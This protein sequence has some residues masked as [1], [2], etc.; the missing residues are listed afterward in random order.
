MT[1]H[2]LLSDLAAMN[3]TFLIDGDSLLLEILCH[4]IV[5]WN[6]SSGEYLQVAYLVEAFLNELLVREAKF[7]LVFFTLT[8]AA[9]WRTRPAGIKGSI[10]P[11]SLLLLRTAV[12]HHL[13]RH[14]AIDVAIYDDW[15][16]A[17]FNEFLDTVH[18]SFMLISPCINYSAGEISIQNG[19]PLELVMAMIS[20]KVFS[21]SVALAFL[22]D[23]H[24]K[25]RAIWAESVL[26]FD[27][28]EHNALNA[29][30][31]RDLLPILRSV[32]NAATGTSS[33]QVTL[34]AEFSEFD[35]PAVV[36]QSTMVAKKIFGGSAETINSAEAAALLSAVLKSSAFEHLEW[37]SIV[38]AVAA[39][40]YLKASASNAEAKALVQAFLVQTVLANNMAP[41][42][43]PRSNIASFD[44]QPA[45]YLA[46]LNNF[47]LYASAVALLAA[48]STETKA[49]EW[50]LVDFL[51]SRLILSILSV[52]Q[53]DGPISDVS[54]L[55]F[56]D[57]MLKELEALWTLASTG[58]PG[59]SGLGSFV[60]FSSP[61]KVVTSEAVSIAS[62]TQLTPIRSSMVDRMMAGESKPELKESDYIRWQ[63]QH[64]D[65]RELVQTYGWKSSR[66]LEYSSLLY[67]D[68][69]YEEGTLHKNKFH[70]QWALLAQSL[71]ARPTQNAV[72]Q[73]KVLMRDETS[74]A[75]QLELL[76]AKLELELKPKTPLN[77]TREKEQ[78]RIKSISNAWR[79][80]PINKRIATLA[81]FVPTTTTAT[82][83][84]LYALLDIHVEQLR[85][86]KVEREN[87]SRITASPDSIQFVQL[88]LKALQ[89][90]EIYDQCVSMIVQCI[91]GLL[92]Y[93]GTNM[94]DPTSAVMRRMIETLDSLGLS[95][96]HTPP[97]AASASS[98]DQ[99]Q[100]PESD[101]TTSSAV[102]FQLSRMGPWMKRDVGAIKDERAPRYLIDSWQKNVL[103]C[104]DEYKSSLVV[105]PT[106]AGKSFMA[107]HAVSRVLETTDGVLVY[108]APTKALVSQVVAEVY[109]KFSKV[110]TPPGTLL[111][112]TFLKDT[113]IAPIAARILVTVPQCLEVLLLSRELAGPG[114]W[115][116]KLKWV[117][118][119]EV[120][121]INME[122]GAVWERVLPLVPCPFLALSATVGAIEL[123]QSWLDSVA[124][125]KQEY[126]SERTPL[127]AKDLP[128][129]KA[130]AEA[131]V[132]A[133]TSGGASKNAK[134][135]HPKLA[136]KAAKQ[137]Q[138]GKGKHAKKAGK[139][140]A[141][142]AASS[143]ADSDAV[144]V[145]NGTEEQKDTEPKRAF[146]YIC[147]T[148]RYSDLY[149]Y[150]V[151]PRFFVDGRQFTSKTAIDTTAAVSSEILSEIRAM[152]P[153][154]GLS[155][156]HFANGYPSSNFSPKDSLNL[157][158]AIAKVANKA[159]TGQVTPNKPLS[160]EAIRAVI[161]MKPEL[162][163][164]ETAVIDQRMVRNFEPVVKGV[165]QSW[166]VEYP[167]LAAM[168]LAELTGDIYE[169][170]EEATLAATPLSKDLG[171][172]L[173]LAESLSSFVEALREQQWLPAIAFNFDP[174]LCERLATSLNAALLEKE[175]SYKQSTEYRNA[176]LKYAEEMKEYEAEQK[177]RDRAS[178]KKKDKRNDEDADKEGDPTMEMPVDPDFELA[179]GTTF[180][181]DGE[182]EPVDDLKL[183]ATRLKNRGVPSA[184]VDALRRGIGVHHAALDTKYRQAVERHFR[185][186]QLKIV[187]ATETLALG[188]NMPCRT[189]IFC[190]D[191]PHLTPLQYRQM[192]GRAGRRGYDPLGRVIFWGLPMHRIT[193]LEGAPLAPIR[194]NFPLSSSFNLRALVLSTADV[195]GTKKRKQQQIDDT[196]A[197]AVNPGAKKAAAA[198]AKKAAAAKKVAA[199]PKVVK[200][201]WD[202]SDSDE[203]DSDDEPVLSKNKKPAKASWDDSSDEEEEA[204]SEEE[205]PVDEV[206]VGA[207]VIA[208]QNNSTEIFRSVE[209]VYTKS[210]YLHQHGATMRS[211]L[212]IH[213]EC[214][215]QYMTHI[216]LVTP[217]G[218]PIDLAGIACHLSWAEPGNL[219]LAKLLATPIIQNICND[220]KKSMEE[221]VVAM[222]KLTAHLFA[223]VPVPPYAEAAFKQELAARAELPKHSTLH[224]SHE[225][226]LPSLPADQQAVIDQHN[227]DVLQILN[228]VILP[229]AK[230]NQPLTAGTN[231]EKWMHLSSLKHLANASEAP[232]SGLYQKIANTT[233]DVV[234]RSP[235][236]ALTGHGDLFTTQADLRT[237]RHGLTAVDFGLLTNEDANGRTLPLN[238]YLFD[239]FTSGNS[240]WLLKYNMMSDADLYA[241]AATYL[242]NL[243]AIRA[244]LLFR[245]PESE[246]KSN[247]VLKV[248]SRLTKEFDLKFRSVFKRKIRQQAYWITVRGVEGY[249]GDL[250]KHILNKTR[251][252]V[253]R[254]K[255]VPTIKNR[256][257]VFKIPCRSD[258]DRARVLELFSAWANPEWWVDEGDSDDEMDDL[259]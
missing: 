169:Q 30:V 110:N 2:E 145:A 160:A 67:Y 98:S 120:H 235:L 33:F 43:R 131:P 251:I 240:D 164:D 208:L 197:E 228:S 76:K 64:K 38:A 37:R 241:G 97:A 3:E 119:D 15:T 254:V 51:D 31:E 96:L 12:L 245:I 232:Q 42:L 6:G 102:R 10:S 195:T 75:Q 70:A 79:S 184:L 130:A 165:F 206:M 93:R 229:Y 104:I 113:R 60:P 190:G 177:R 53:A 91:V 249:N 189:T 100:V 174:D 233:L 187:F 48:S 144:A 158:E 88:R 34:N 209:H 126:A 62:T 124:T 159:T 27:F 22:S 92:E 111:C 238:G 4:T 166:C 117:I 203:E 224:C 69:E 115:R 71:E 29:E 59:T 162:M 18:P 205:A 47:T 216:G 180:T 252:S 8:Q 35:V 236:A 21:K 56:S 193:Y 127:Y 200:S 244:A 57:R 191:S 210:L 87:A 11:Q 26:P 58:T 140:T 141:P 217:L 52:L 84:W 129:A 23:I 179:E 61:F 227:K 221:K 94:L 257:Y 146:E 134:P 41:Q 259:D 90:E 253:L 7:K 246:L 17:P 143:A 85:T 151:I 161:A 170:M 133:A 118:F 198:K 139:D 108:V 82:F 16:C 231:T 168:V 157:Y 72:L 25:E 49:R 5:E 112:G 154:T 55:G 183:E 178:K 172:E 128:S 186:G 173:F 204:K 199:E 175:T 207:N 181:R 24:F 9:Y 219:V 243:K 220:T 20:L 99:L 44:R 46:A 63:D 230:T 163:F 54:T 155:P 68:K 28:S 32:H 150:I 101:A 138:G 122:D 201:S 13:D 182:V 14:T 36:A 196:A 121:C 167:D 152:H 106:S 185:T 213:T 255:K 105:A 78:S 218:K 222:L 225:L 237:M 215:L 248:F 95:T 107:Y 192:S 176:R 135:L 188:I 73:P 250:Q 156:E 212:D 247:F 137:Q 114:G 242:E 214:S 103:D 74:A 149:K 223:R 258:S 136:A 123:F 65:A 125:A 83:D 89:R 148:H 45:T 202:D 234:A 19:F 39:H 77:E 153:W 86:L 142:A 66:A 256:S 132:S 171:S 50:D 147:H 40:F 226:F 116:S 239:M 211:Q 1:P 80:S 194:G 81:A 109:S